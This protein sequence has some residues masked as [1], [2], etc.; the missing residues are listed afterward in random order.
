MEQSP[1][2]FLSQE[3]SDN[4]LLVIIKNK[5]IAGHVH[6]IPGLMSL[7]R[8]PSVVFV[9]IDTLDDIRNN[10]YNELFVAGG[11]IVSD[12]LVLNPDFHHS[13]STGCTADVP[14]TAQFSREHLE[15]ESSLQ[16]PQ[17]T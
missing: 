4:R 5:D 11:C 2:S 10:S 13:R 14:G 15:V 17:E 8:H 1:V 9:G 16:N 3:N 12:E 6:K 7:K